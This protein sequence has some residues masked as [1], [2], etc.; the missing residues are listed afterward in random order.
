MANL[1]IRSGQWDK[2]LEHL[3]HI[4]YPGEFFYE[5]FSALAMHGKGNKEQATKHFDAIK[6]TLGSSKLSD[7]QVP[8][9]KWDWGESSE[10]LK[11]LFISYGFN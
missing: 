5:F 7:L 2:A 10:T 3:T 9:K 6:K 11:P 8:L 4:T 1:Y